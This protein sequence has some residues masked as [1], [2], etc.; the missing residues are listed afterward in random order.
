MIETRGYK[1]LEGTPTMVSQEIPP[2]ESLLRH[3]R[4]KPLQFQCTASLHVL[5]PALIESETVAHI[6]IAVI[7]NNLKPQLYELYDS[8]R[9]YQLYANMM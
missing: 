1:G 3:L 8:S 7:E 6:Y 5:L 2:H 4:I 9:H